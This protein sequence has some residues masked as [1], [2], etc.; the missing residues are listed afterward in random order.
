M[1]GNV[2]FICIIRGER[3]SPPKSL[4]GVSLYEAVKAI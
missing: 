1:M 3:K 4:P 2:E